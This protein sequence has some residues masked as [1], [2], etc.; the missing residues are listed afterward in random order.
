MKHKPVAVLRSPLPVPSGNF[1][2]LCHTILL[3]VGIDRGQRAR[4]RRSGWAEEPHAFVERF[5]S[6]RLL[7]PFLPPQRKTGIDDRSGM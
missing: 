3:V 5:E 1:V 4:P 2:R 6:L 7:V